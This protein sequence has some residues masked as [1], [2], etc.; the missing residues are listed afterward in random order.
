MVAA[1]FS[2]FKE[3]FCMDPLQSLYKHPKLYKQIFIYELS[4]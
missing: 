3:A 1:F 2:L 4:F